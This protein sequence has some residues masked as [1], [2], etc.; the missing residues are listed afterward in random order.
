M[1][2]SLPLFSPHINR[3]GAG[4][5]ISNLPPGD[6]VIFDRS[7]ISHWPKMFRFF[8]H[9]A[10]KNRKKSIF[11]QKKI[12]KKEKLQNPLLYRNFAEK[13]SSVSHLLLGRCHKFFLSPI[14]HLGDGP[15]KVHTFFFIRILFSLD[16]FSFVISTINVLILSDSYKKNVCTISHLLHEA[17]P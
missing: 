7:P 5:R 11:C 15:K 16:Y 14:S 4:V 13:F 12:D 6:G 2:N 10:R 9:F 1:N 8:G 17:P 3:R